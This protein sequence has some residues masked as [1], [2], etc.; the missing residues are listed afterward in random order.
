MAAEHPEAEQVEFDELDRLDVAFVVLH[1]DTAGH[2]G[3]LERCDV[4][5]WRGR[6][7]HSAG[8][9]RQMSRKA[10][11]SAGQLQP[12]L[13]GRQ[14]D[15]RRP[16]RRRASRPR[17]GRW[18]AALAALAATVVCLWAPLYRRL[19]SLDLRADELADARRARSLSLDLSLLRPSSLTG[20]TRPRACLEAV[21][22]GR[23]Y[24]APV[25]RRSG[26]SGRP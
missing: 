1:D 16:I 7:E 19:T 17:S 6:D 24:A 20:S 26:R 25:M 2:R 4:D 18:R 5:Q 10:V 22:N 21:M 13:P 11:N 14:P 12:A 9:D 23:A 3:S 8:V 15:R